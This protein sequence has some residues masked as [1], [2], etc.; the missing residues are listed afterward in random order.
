M[1]RPTHVAWYAL[2][3]R[4]IPRQ[5][6]HVSISRHSSTA[7]VRIGLVAAAA[8]LGFAACRATTHAPVGLAWTA[9]KDGLTVDLV[10]TVHIGKPGTNAWPALIASCWTNTKV[11][12]VEADPTNPETV[13][14]AFHRRAM[15]PPSEPSLETRLPPE[16]VNR[17]QTHVR[18]VP[19]WQRLKPWAVANVVHLQ[20]ILRWGYRPGQ[21][22]DVRLIERARD[23]GRLVIELEGADEQLRIFDEAPWDVQVA[24]LQTTLDD[25]DSGHTQWEVERLIR[26]VDRGKLEVLEAALQELRDRGDPAGRYLLPRLFQQRH[27]VMAERIEAVARRHG[28]CLVAVGAMHFAGPDSLLD[29]LRA[30]GFSVQRREVR[31]PTPCDRVQ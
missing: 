19:S 15:L 3:E 30:R 9:Q 22:L 1:V 31:S 16:L 25:L 7:R 5:N 18:A 23:E 6:W 14:E 11:L 24:Y 10:A 29:A 21:G 8:L 27:V 4:Q 17:L 13:Q 12:V 28:R 2:G 20:S 26:A